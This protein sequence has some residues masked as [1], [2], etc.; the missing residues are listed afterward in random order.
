MINQPER[1]EELQKVSAKKIRPLRTLFILFAAVFCVW[2]GWIAWML[3]VDSYTRLGPYFWIH[4]GFCNE[5]IRLDGRTI[6]SGDVLSRIAITTVACTGKTNISSSNF[7]TALD[8]SRYRQWSNPAKAAAL[9]KRL[10]PAQ[11]D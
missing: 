6:I 7:V 10:Q 4:P 3:A 1:G 9:A 2:L 5:S 11:V 8:I